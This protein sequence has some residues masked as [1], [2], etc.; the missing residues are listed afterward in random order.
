MPNARADIAL[1]QGSSGKCANPHTVV[2]LSGHLYD[3][4]RQWTTLVDLHGSLPARN[5]CQEVYVLDLLT[6]R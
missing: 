4:M 3:F 1:Y 6:V 2:R 5:Q